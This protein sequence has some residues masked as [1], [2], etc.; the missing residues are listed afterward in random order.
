MKRPLDWLRPREAPVPEHQ[1]PTEKV[2]DKE[3]NVTSDAVHTASDADRDSDEISV[4]A[5][6]G[7]QDVE[8]FAKVWTKRDIAL[9][10][11]T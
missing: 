3:A 9:A 11:I 5:Q 7:V 2:A 1:V 4:S 6:A 10:Y 8:A